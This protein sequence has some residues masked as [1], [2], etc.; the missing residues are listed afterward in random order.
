MNW[1]LILQLSLFGL[2]MGIATVFWI[3]SNVEPV[4]WLLIFLVCAYILARQAVPTPFLHG[5]ATG[6]V[7]SVWI[8]VAHVLLFTQ[9]IAAHPAEADMMKKMPVPDSR[10][11]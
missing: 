3:P 7:N 1:K 4:L 5:L 2:A 8:T 11:S 6:V 9:Y 10:G